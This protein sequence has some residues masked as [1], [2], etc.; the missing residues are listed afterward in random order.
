MSAPLKA[1]TRSGVL[2]SD[3]L[4]PCLR[5]LSLAAEPESA[6]GTP[7][8]FASDR[9]WTAGADR[10]DLVPKTQAAECNASKAHMVR[11]NNTSLDGSV[12]LCPRKLGRQ[13]EAPTLDEQ[14]GRTQGV[15][16]GSRLTE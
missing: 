1:K 6:D 9:N 5:L 2:W 16:Y 13:E 11:N 15:E 14:P 4:K 3:T 7:S 8:E 12:L 10:R